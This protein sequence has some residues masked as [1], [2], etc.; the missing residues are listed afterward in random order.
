MK[1]LWIDTETTGLN[2]VRHDIIQ[3]AGMV[4]IDGKV[5]D[6]FDLKCAPYDIDAV[7]AKALQVNGIKRDDLM[8]RPNPKDTLDVFVNRLDQ[9]VNRFD[10]EDKLICAGHNVGFDLDFTFNWFKKG[11]NDYFYSYADYHKLDTVPLAMWTNMMRLTNF[12]S[13]KL[14]SLCND[15]GI[16]IVGAHDAM[17]DVKA[18]RALIRKLSSILRESKNGTKN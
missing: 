6:E 18:A 2:A 10:K 16:E 15:L 5:V 8:K 13:Y 14:E 17:V 9:H 12:K 3:L 7:D 1:L 4:V 11:G